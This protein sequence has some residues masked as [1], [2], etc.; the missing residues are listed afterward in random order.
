MRRS[1]RQQLRVFATVTIDHEK[2]AILLDLCEMGL[3][4]Q[5]TRTFKPGCELYIAF[6]LPNSYTRVE[7]SAI[8]IWSDAKGQTGVQF[9]EQ[10]MQ[11]LVDDWVEET[12]SGKRS[13]QSEKRP[14]VH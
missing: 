12:A 13:A 4:L 1:E 2:E 7:G 10:S 14:T 11:Q 9:V 3:R 5:S 8:V 6:F